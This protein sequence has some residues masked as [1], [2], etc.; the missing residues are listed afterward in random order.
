MSYLIQIPGSKLK[1][2]VHHFWNEHDIPIILNDVFNSDRSYTFWFLWFVCLWST[3]LQNRILSLIYHYS[4][5]PPSSPASKHSQDE[6]RLC[7]VWAAFLNQKA[8]ATTL[9]LFI[10]WFCFCSLAADSVLWASRY[11]RPSVCVF[12]CVYHCSTPPHRND[13]FR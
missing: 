2:K 6:I 12:E 1:L 5:N 7:S 3:D 13:A 9:S 8:S 11:T 10:L 4:L